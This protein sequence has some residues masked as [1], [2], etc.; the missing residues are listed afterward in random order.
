MV[1][2]KDLASWEVSF[3]SSSP[4]LLPPSSKLKTN[5]T[6]KWLAILPVWASLVVTVA[7]CSACFLHLISL[8]LGP[9]FITGLA[10][11][12]KLITDSLTCTA[13]GWLVYCSGGDSRT[14][15]GWL[16]YCS[17]GDSC[18]AVGWL[19]HWTLGGRLVLA[20][21]H[22]W[23]LHQICVNMRENSNSKTLFSKDCSLGS[24]R[25]V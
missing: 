6:V 7:L 20:L 23:L 8:A 21:W 25:P 19:L 12:V 10:L 2:V 13:V 22:W 5:E 9:C 18:T 24:F 14:A 1:E 15:V 17:G 3:A 4:P 16:M 11:V